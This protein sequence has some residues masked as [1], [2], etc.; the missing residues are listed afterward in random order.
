M[1]TIKLIALDLDGTLLNMEKKVPQ[2]NYEALKQCET[3]GI[4]IVPATGRGVG[5][6]PPM[7]RELPGANYAITTNGARS[8]ERR[9]G[10]ECRSRWSPY[11]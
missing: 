6:I 1:K 3:A 2:G 5:G 9:V 7:I 11:H 10:K 8:E 4:Q